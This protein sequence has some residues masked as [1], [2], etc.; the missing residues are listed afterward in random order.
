VR[1]PL[2]RLD[3]RFDHVEG[4]VVRDHGELIARLEATHSN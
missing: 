4:V 2:D 3:S 1:A